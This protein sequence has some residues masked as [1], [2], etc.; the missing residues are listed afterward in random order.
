MAVLEFRSPL[1]LVLVCLLP[2]VNL[3]APRRRAW[4]V[5]GDR[6]TDVIIVGKHASACGYGGDC[7]YSIRESSARTL[8]AGHGTELTA[9]RDIVRYVIE[10]WCSSL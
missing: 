8:F 2:R 4:V 3:S 5:P 9:E 10:K 6:A 1:V 7:T